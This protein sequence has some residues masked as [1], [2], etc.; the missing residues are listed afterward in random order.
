M[1]FR[2]EPASR[3]DNDP[4]LVQQILCNIVSRPER[5]SI[6]LFSDV[7]AYVRENI[8]RP[9]RFDTGY[10]LYRC[11]RIID[12]IPPAQE[13]SCHGVDLIVRA[14]QGSEGRMLRYRGGVGGDLALHFF[15]RRNDLLLRA[16]IAD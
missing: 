8:K 13:L 15:S 10:S 2:A 5:F 4:F 11:Y 6:K 1:V 3:H 12:E 14:G 16:E 9:F 7:P